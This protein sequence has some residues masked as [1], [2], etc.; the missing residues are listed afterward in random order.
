MQTQHLLPRRGR[1]ARTRIPS[2]ALTFVV[3]V[4]PKVSA[5]EGDATHLRCA[6]K[7]VVHVRATVPRRG[8]ARFVR[9]DLCG[10]IC[11]EAKYV[12]SPSSP[13]GTCTYVQPKGTPRATRTN[14]RFVTP[15]VLHVRAQVRTVANVHA[16][17][18]S[19]AM[20]HV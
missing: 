10:T 11:A 13:K 3:H 8:R 18:L 2:V 6:Q 12:H 20:L 17:L 4:A 1:V 9:N 5:T 19:K 14:L 15:S 7:S 16:T